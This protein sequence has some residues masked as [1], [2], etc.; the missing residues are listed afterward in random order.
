[1]GDIFEYLENGDAK[2]LRILNKMETAM[3]CG[4]HF[5]LRAGQKLIRCLLDECRRYLTIQGFKDRMVECDRVFNEV[6]TGGDFASE[7]LAV[8]DA[9]AGDFRTNVEQ[10]HPSISRLPWS[11]REKSLPTSISS[12]IPFSKICPRAKN[13]RIERCSGKNCSIATKK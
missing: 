13:W 1:M 9:M 5:E 8:G 10:V 4:L 12:V 2:E 6:F 7:E 3:I 11:N